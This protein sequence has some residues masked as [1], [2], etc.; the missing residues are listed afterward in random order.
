MTQTSISRVRHAFT[1]G[2]RPEI[3]AISNSVMPPY[4]LS[5]PEFSRD[6][7]G[8]PSYK[9]PATPSFKGLA[10]SFPPSFTSPSD[11]LSQSVSVRPP[12]QI[13]EPAFLSQ[14]NHLLS[15]DRKP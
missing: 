3:Q 5:V 10:F 6:E 7:M 1:T 13:E 4:P 9:Y 15:M 14:L 11:L 8:I 2:M 12:P